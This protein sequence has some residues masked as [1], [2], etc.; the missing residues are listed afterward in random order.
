M[1]IIQLLVLLTLAI[2]LIVA[3]TT[4]KSKSKNK[5]ALKH[6]KTVSK[7]NS[8]KSHSRN[9]KCPGKVNSAAAVQSMKFPDVANMGYVNSD[10]YILQNQAGFKNAKIWPGHLPERLNYFPYTGEFGTAQT[11]IHNKYYY[12]G[13]LHLSKLAQVNCDFYTT[14]PRGCV[15]QKGCGWCGQSNNC[16]G[17]SPLG[18]IAPCVRSTFIYTMPTTEWNPLKASAINIHAQDKTGHSMLSVVHEPNLRD[19]P[20]AKPYR[21]D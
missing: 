15:N 12:D 3:K 1:K 6:R 5:A 20:V 19:A 11:G 8:Y 13:S 9:K 17:A 18:P 21:L 4:I 2:S 16:I 7:V 10:P 14:N